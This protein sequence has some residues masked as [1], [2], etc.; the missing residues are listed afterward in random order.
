MCREVLAT[1]G[2]EILRSGDALEAEVW[3][4]YLLGQFGS[5]PL[6]GEP[7]PVAAIGQLVS[8]ARQRRLPEARVCLQALAVVATGG[9]RTQARAAAGEL[10]ASQVRSSRPD[11]QRSDRGWVDGQG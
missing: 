7:D 1:Q 11:C 8:V 10:A 2:R 4:S 5:A 6:V 9:L 3:A